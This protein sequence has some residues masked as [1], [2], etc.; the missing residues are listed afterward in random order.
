[1][2]LFRE[3]NYNYFCWWNLLPKTCFFAVTVLKKTNKL[4]KTIYHFCFMKQTNK[5]KKKTPSIHIFHFPCSLH[6]CSHT[7]T[8][9]G[10]AGHPAV[11]QPSH[12]S[13]SPGKQ[14]HKTRQQS[15]SDGALLGINERLISQVTKKKWGKKQHHCQWPR[16]FS[17]SAAYLTSK[18]IQTCIN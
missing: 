8:R 3:D 5:I 17:A 7:Y 2:K 11:R 16:T 15:R 14:L 1:M 6:T 18:H 9:A 4:S 10:S 13:E 12:L